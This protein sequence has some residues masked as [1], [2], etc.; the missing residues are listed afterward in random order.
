MG[1]CKEFVNYLRTR[2]S[3]EERRAD[4]CLFRRNGKSL[5][6][7]AESKERQIG[8]K[9]EVGGEAAPEAVRFGGGQRRWCYDLLPNSSRIS[10]P[11]MAERAMATSRP[12]LSS[13]AWATLRRIP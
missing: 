7:F 10:A 2:T 4:D 6:R 9:E 11:A 5:S 3:R 13:Q 8:S 12:R 1:W